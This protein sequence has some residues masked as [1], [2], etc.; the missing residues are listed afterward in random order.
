MVS[1]VTVVTVPTRTT[2]APLEHGQPG[3]VWGFA[4][5]L[6]LLGLF[7]TV[8]VVNAAIPARAMDILLSFAAFG[9]GVGFAGA[10]A[11][12]LVCRRRSA[13]AQIVVALLSFVGL[14]LLTGSVLLGVNRL[15]DRSAGTPHVARI[16]K[17]YV[18]GQDE[19]LYNV[20]HDSVSVASWLEDGELIKVYVGRTDALAL[21]VGDS[22]PVI[23]HDG[24]LGWPWVERYEAR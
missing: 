23:A 1:V 2:S 11:V 5:G 4:L 6:P 13:A 9:G 10:L 7:A 12:G 15:A 17:K 20:S 22:I 14:A 19:D 3:A 24:R 8:G 18:P 21:Q 16:V